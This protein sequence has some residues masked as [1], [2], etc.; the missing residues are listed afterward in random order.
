MRISLWPNNL[1]FIH[2]Y[3]LL[4]FYRKLKEQ[5][6]KVKRGDEKGVMIDG[7]ETDIETNTEG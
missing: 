6:K 1:S 4:L 2:K 3:F 7:I 5:E